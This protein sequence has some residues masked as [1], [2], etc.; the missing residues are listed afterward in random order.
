MKKVTLLCFLLVFMSCSLS[1]KDSGIAYYHHE[2]SDINRILNYSKNHTLAFKNQ[3][4]EILNFPIDKI[5]DEYKTRYATGFGF[6]SP[7]ASYHYFYDNKDINFY[8]TDT[9]P[10]QFNLKY[11]FY[12]WPD[13]YET[14]KE[15]IYTKQTSSFYAYLDFS[16]FNGDS[17]G[18]VKIDYNKPK[19]TLT[20]GNKTYTN[21]FI[22]KAKKT[23]NTRNVTTLYY[24]EFEGVIGFDD[25]KNLEWRLISNYN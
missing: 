25:L 24:D 9:D 11:N 8:S 12:R 4:D 13:D 17:Y 7:A 6:F 15:N 14:A 1:D 10:Y 22:F 21:V 18:R 23:T 5:S 20:I 19:S 2:Q 16:L 3:N